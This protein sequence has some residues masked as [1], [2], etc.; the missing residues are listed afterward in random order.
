[1]IANYR[2]AFGNEALLIQKFDDLGSDPDQFVSRILKHIGA[3]PDW[4]LPAESRERI[5]A[6]QPAEM[7]GIVRWYLA[8]L[9]I[10]SVRELDRI[11]DG[12][13]ANWVQQLTAWQQDA[14][15]SWSWGRRWNRW[16]VSAPE[17]ASYAIFES[18]RDMKRRR[19][20]DAM[21]D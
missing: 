5:Y 7:P 17:K 15:P 4:S 18:I 19:A 9:W 11:L 20:I 1:M 13:V 21:L 6:N 2:S 8:D 14:A 16:V 12:Q 3:D 10:D